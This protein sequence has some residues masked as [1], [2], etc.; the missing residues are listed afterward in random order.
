MKK[1]AVNNYAI[2]TGIT[3]DYPR[4]IAMYGH[5]PMT[6]VAL[7]E[8]LKIIEFDWCSLGEISFSAHLSFWIPNFI[9]FLSS[10]DFA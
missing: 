7:K 1:N 6:Q 8:K 4:H 5:P 10:K 3:E 9:P 2:T